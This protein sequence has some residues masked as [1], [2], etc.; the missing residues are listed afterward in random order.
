MSTADMKVEIDF[1]FLKLREN[2]NVV[3]EHSVTAKCWPTRF[4][5]GAPIE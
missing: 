5:S 3:K 2:E 4:V 1:E